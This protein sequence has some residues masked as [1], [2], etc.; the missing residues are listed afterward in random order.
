LDEAV[1]GVEAVGRVEKV[2][3]VEEEMGVRRMGSGNGMKY[4]AFPG[5][6]QGAVLAVY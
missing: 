6:A 1:E 4:I 3:R 5:V 2:E